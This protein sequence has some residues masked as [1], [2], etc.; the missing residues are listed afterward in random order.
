MR[1]CC[2]RQRDRERDRDKE[3][4]RVETV[5]G[6]PLV[7]DLNKLFVGFSESPSREVRRWKRLERIGVRLNQ[8]SQLADEQ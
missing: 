8:T 2:E 6:G 3:E 5:R 1:C 7:V 4:Y